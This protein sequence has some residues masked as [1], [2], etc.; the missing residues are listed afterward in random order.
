ML[1]I[2]F[3]GIGLMAWGIALAVAALAATLLGA[4]KALLVRR[5]GAIAVRTATYLD[6]VAVAVLAATHPVFLILAG[7]Y[8]GSLTLALPPRAITIVSHAAVVVLLLQIAR[9]GDTGVR[10]WLEHYRQRRSGDDVAATTSTAAL[11]FIAR[12]ALWLVIALMILDNLGVNITTLIASLGIGGIAVALALQNIL[13]DLFSSLSIVL[14]KPFV[15]GDFIIVDGSAGTVEYVGLKTTRLRSLGGEQ[16]IFSNS[17]LLK[18]RIHNYK[19][20]QTR[21][22]AF[23][24]GVTY[25]STEQQVQAIP[26]IVEDA[27]GAQA[28]ARFDRAHFK[29]FGDSALIY[30]IVYYVLSADYDAYMDIQQGINLALFRRFAQEGI[31]F[32]YPTQT[33]HLARRQAA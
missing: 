17:D 26:K 21:R 10:E 4:L 16:I 2:S 32:A 23:S 15:I 33:L 11:G 30:E 6:D 3:W 19:R 1:T 14:D 7:L 5:L 22:I 20:M 27:V 29:E 18:A 9:W 8:L 12:T 24:I 28:E 31:E 13:G 25:Q